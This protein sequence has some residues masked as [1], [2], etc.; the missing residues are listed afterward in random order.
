MAPRAGCGITAENSGGRALPC[1]E[2]SK[3]AYARNPLARTDFGRKWN[4]LAVIGALI[5]AL[6]AGPLAAD[7]L[8]DALAMFRAGKY[9]ECADAA[10]QAIESDKA[11]ELWPVLKLRSELTLGRYEDAAR[12]LDEALP[13]IETS[14]LLRWWGS[15]ALR[16]RDE[17]DRAEQLR[18]ELDALA[19]S[20]NPR[21]REAENLVIL[22]ELYLSRGADPK[23]VLDELFEPVKKQRPNFA[24]AHLASGELA[25][26]KGDLALAADSFRQALAIDPGLA[27]AQFGLAR[28]FA[29]TDEAQS[30]TALQ[31]ALTLNP[32]HIPSL[33]FLTDDR[34]DSE[35][36][37]EAEEIL[38]KI[39]AINPE[40][41]RAW[42]YRAALAHLK[43][44]A[45]TEASCRQA[46]LRHWSTN[47]E[48]D[49][50]IGEK[51]S[52]KYRFSEG[53]GYQRRA[54]EFDPNYSPARMQLAQDLLRLGEE[55]EGWRLATEAYD[56]DG[57]DILAHN[58][59]TLRENMAKFQVLERE[60]LALKM[61]PHEAAVYGERV[62]DHLA[63]A[64]KK[65]CAKYE[66]VLDK[67]VIVELFPRQQDFAI[68]TFGMPGGAGY[69]GVC[70]GRVITA[71]S[72]ASQVG[73]PVNW[74]ATLWHE[75][76]HVITL[77]KT[78]NKMPRW[79]SEGISVYEERQADPTWGQSINP[80]YRKMLLADDLTPVSRLSGAFLHPP[81]PLHLQFAYFESSL[82]VEYLIEKHGLPRLLK[83][84]VELGEGIGIQDALTR[85][86]GPPAALDEKFAEFARSK[87]NSLAPKLDWSEIQIPAEADEASLAAL[88]E[89]HPKNYLAISRLANKRI[90]DKKW[91]PAIETLR[92]WIALY[93]EQAGEG[94]PH[95]LLATAYRELGE[96]REERKALERL[97]ALS[98]DDEAAFSRLAELAS[99]AKEWPA[100][101]KYAERLMAI[102]PLKRTSQQLLADL[103]SRTGDDRKAIAAYRA[104]LRLAPPDIAEVHYR[105]AKSLARSGD[106]NAARRHVL[107]ALEEAPRFRAAQRL[108][109]EV[110]GPE[111][112]AKPTETVKEEP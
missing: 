24:E 23:R 48:V 47:P 30:R 40:H 72:P 90:A 70:F 44:D 16:F 31:T 19:K 49:F 76:C 66:V 37:A 61:D 57:Y 64:K 109:L 32:Q 41:P 68:R 107:L 50:A 21:F 7:E 42:A 26:D 110:V 93:P 36:Y 39:F 13:R 52:R 102:D 69:L 15:E 54:L 5:A 86:Y 71:N 80:R 83:T 2:I 103:A 111:P 33:L 25:L 28:A 106:S 108:L 79:L 75:F 101:L 12:T 17:P 53:A 67:P 55:D 6:F 99:E 38:A 14:V 81:S 1:P 27:D 29:P 20:G 56:A 84:L 22:G 87:A 89:K 85:N 43:S 82:V 58:L 18:D 51:L 95:S 91:R 65:L 4:P 8:E 77:H 104:V 78:N 112:P 98:A 97:A 34:V 46:A 100:A 59:V 60:G 3:T 74:R 45:K 88:L 10:G 96:F 94:N 9:A 63:E 105:L 92:A 73:R 62:L 11:N 35:Q